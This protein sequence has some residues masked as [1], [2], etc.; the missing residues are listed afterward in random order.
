MDEYLELLAD[1]SVPTEDYD[2]I[3]RYNDFRK[4]F[5]ETDQGR[6]VLRQILGWGHILKSH[7]VGMPRPI[8]PYT[9]LSLE[10]ERNLA[11]HIFSVMLV[12]PKKRPDKQAT[13][14]KE[15]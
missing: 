10:G 11:L 13:V 5:L 6:R 3:D 7:L 1:L 2:P 14:S 12:E 9:I 4:V 8:D 15:E